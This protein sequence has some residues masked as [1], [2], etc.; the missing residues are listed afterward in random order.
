MIAWLSFSGS[1]NTII[2]CLLMPRTSTG[3]WFK[4]NSWP[5]R[6]STPDPESLAA[7]PGHQLDTS[8]YTIRFR[9]TSDSGAPN[10]ARD[11]YPIKSY[12]LPYISIFGSAVPNGGSPLIN[13]IKL[14]YDE[15]VPSV[16]LVPGVLQPL[17]TLSG[18]R[19]LQANRSTVI[20][21]S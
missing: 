6:W 7:W 20:P 10:W 11:K 5:D 3:T 12:L 14:P 2:L 15:C 16:I 8:Y 19:R 18:P 21:A 9:L 17:R 13:L 1:V 4:A